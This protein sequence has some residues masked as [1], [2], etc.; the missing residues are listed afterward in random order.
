VKHW[1]AEQLLRHPWEED[2]VTL[3]VPF[4]IER[5]PCER[6]CPITTKVL[7]ILTE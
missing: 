1:L 3:S 2:P 5:S 7:E 4:I 6:E